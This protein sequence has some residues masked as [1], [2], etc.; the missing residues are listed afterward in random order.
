MMVRGL[1][2]GTTQSGTDFNALKGALAEAGNKDFFNFQSPLYKGGNE[3]KK[4]AKKY[5]TSAVKL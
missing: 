3:L 5:N 2:L 4:R 1:A